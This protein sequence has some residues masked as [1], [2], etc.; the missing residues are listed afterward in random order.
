MDINLGMLGTTILY[1]ICREVHCINIV[2]INDG[3]LLNRLVKLLK[4]L[5]KPTYFHDSVGD[6]SVFGFCVGDSSVFS[7][8]AEPAIR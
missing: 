8:C 5:T 3:G 7:F 4:Q 1:G 2:A 6:S